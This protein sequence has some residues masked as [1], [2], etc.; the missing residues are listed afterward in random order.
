MDFDRQ[1][2]Q[3]KYSDTMPEYP[4]RTLF[5]HVAAKGIQAGSVIGFAMTPLHV[6]YSKQPLSLSWR[7]CSF[8]GTVIGLTGAMSMLAVRQMT[9]SLTVEGE[10]KPLSAQPH[11]A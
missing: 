4:A 9:G 1:V 10:G 6:L 7:K 8:F 5:I 11:T 2:D 3:S